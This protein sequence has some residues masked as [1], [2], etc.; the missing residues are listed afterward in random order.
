MKGICQDTTPILGR[1]ADC[2][3]KRSYNRMIHLHWALQH[4]A[5]KCI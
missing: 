5:L 3:K 2:R 4:I 1:F